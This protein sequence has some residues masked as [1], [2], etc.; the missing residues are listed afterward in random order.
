MPFRSQAQWRWAFA[1]KKPWASEWAKQTPRKLSDLPAYSKKAVTTGNF[2]ATAG[3]VIGGSQ[4]RDAQGQFANCEDVQNTN[5][6]SSMA[7][8]MQSTE[9]GRL[10]ENEKRKLL[11]QQLRQQ[12]GLEP[13]SSTSGGSG[14]ISA[15][16]RKRQQRAEQRQNEANVHSQVGPGGSLGMALSDFADPENPK[17]LPNVLAFQLEE[18]G[19]VEPSRFG[20]Y[21]I[22]GAGRAYLGAA[23]SGD[24][25]AARE[26]M[27]RARETFLAKQEQLAAQ[28]EAQAQQSQ[29]DQLAQAQQ[30]Y[31]ESIEGTPFERRIA[32]AQKRR[33]QMMRGSSSGAKK[34]AASSS[35]PTY[36]SGKVIAGS[37]TKSTVKSSDGDI[38]MKYEIPRSVL[39]SMIIGSDYANHYNVRHDSL[40]LVTKAI[41]GE[42]FTIQDVRRLKSFQS[43]ID[44]GMGS[45]EEPTSAWIQHQLVGGLYGYRWADQILAEFESEMSRYKEKTD[46]D[47]RIPSLSASTEAIRGLDLQF[48]FKRGGT[49]DSIAI[50]RKI[51][52]R[53]PLTDNEIR[54]IHSYLERHTGDRKDG[55]ANPANPSKEYINWQL[56]G[57]DAGLSWSSEALSS[58]K[59]KKEKFDDEH[60]VIKLP[61]Y[62]SKSSINFSP[63]SG[64]REA[65]KRGLELRSK[66]NRGGTSVGIARARDLSNGKNVSPSTIRRMNSFFARHAVDKRPDWSNP[67][68][69]S[70]GYIAWLLWGGDSGRAWASKVSRQLDAKEKRKEVSFQ[71][72]H[73]TKR[74]KRLQAIKRKSN[75]NSDTLIAVQE[76][77]RH[78]SNEPKNP[79]LWS[80]AIAEA[81]KKYRTYPSAYANG[82][83]AKWYK[84]HGGTWR[85]EKGFAEMV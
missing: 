79:Q 2:S 72:N 30:A 73:S 42:R 35:S 65:A 70:N 38:F 8:Y 54:E 78:K 68:N 47:P 83:A 14:K 21:Y 24:V 59:L 39:T 84:K 46:E 25:F 33:E 16:E 77:S 57:G 69:P 40:N 81:K 12:L 67:S 1:N 41:N 19:L 22:T 13:A 64:V 52:N 32:L 80:R 10:I 31:I 82:Y 53:K 5:P 7:N 51:A 20:S 6:L 56:F 27:M 34:P 60:A 75:P 29:A 9:I 66:F 44:P 58:L 63:P 15:A 36:G 85:S 61:V 49:P 11:R 3:Q 71:S 17:M 4:C 74:E 23:R 48:Y 37:P 28:Q 45:R 62:K 18:L 50:A 55:W 43:R 76:Y 26:A